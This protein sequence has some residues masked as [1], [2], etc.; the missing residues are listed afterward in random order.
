MI[1]EEYKQEKSEELEKRIENSND[2]IKYLS[3]KHIIKENELDESELVILAKRYK[4]TGDMAGSIVAIIFGVLLCVFIFGVIL[5][6][7]GSMNLARWNNN[8]KIKHECVAWSPSRKKIILF[9]SHNVIYGFDPRDIKY[10]SH[11]GNDNIAKAVVKFSEREKFY[12]L[13][14][15]TYDDVQSCNFQIGKYQ[16]QL[17]DEDNQEKEA[18]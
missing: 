2:Y 17:N 14:K 10:I 16:K 5:V 12:Y 1:D 18:R 9:E 13:G 7:F 6:V 8:Y 4:S 15:S 11:D 3:E